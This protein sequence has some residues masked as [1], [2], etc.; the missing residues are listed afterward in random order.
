MLGGLPKLFDKN[1]VIGFLLP[2]ALAVFAFAWLF[3]QFGFLQPLRKPGVEEKLLGEL[4]YLLLLT[5]GLA[6]ILMMA[7]TFLHRLLG[8]YV[9][10]VSG[11][12]GWR[13]K[14][15]ERRAVLIAEL[16]RLGTRRKAEGGDFPAEDKARVKQVLRELAQQFAP[17]PAEV[18]PTRFGNVLDSFQSYPSQLYGASA[19]AVWLRLISVIPKEFR[20]EL[21]DSRSQVNCVLN[22]FFIVPVVAAAAAAKVLFATPWAK[23]AAAAA[24]RDFGGLEPDYPVLIALA[25]LL[26]MPALYRSAVDRAA[27]WGGM[28]KAA[29]DCFLPKLAGQM[30]YADAASGEARS[31]FW[32]EFSAFAVYRQAMDPGAYRL[33]G[34]KEPP[35]P[36]PAAKPR[37]LPPLLEVAPAP[38]PASGGD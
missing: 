6:L 28:V 14:E 4:T 13:L 7:N 38:P 34:A 21:D 16:D 3:P 20:S 19:P 1:F 29:F 27:A 22:L 17:A 5:Y 15:N 25:A 11:F 37:L 8:G 18:R 26:L 36:P 2:V 30:G 24:D 23:V 32:K 12:S 10:P 9:A 33:A 35:A 31:R